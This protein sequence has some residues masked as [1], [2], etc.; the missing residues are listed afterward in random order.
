M[1]CRIYMVMDTY[2]AARQKKISLRDHIQASDALFVPFKIGPGDILL[3]WG[4]NIVVVCVIH[5]HFL[6]SDLWEPFYDH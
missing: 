5:F 6:D 1:I 4:C 2:V 3:I